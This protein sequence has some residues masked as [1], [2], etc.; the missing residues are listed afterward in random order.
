VAPWS[1]VSRGGVG[2]PLSSVSTWELVV[3][4]VANVSRY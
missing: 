1:M 3:G 4:P 2:W